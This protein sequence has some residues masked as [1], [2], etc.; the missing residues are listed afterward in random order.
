MAKKKP[1]AP[2]ALVGLNEDQLLEIIKAASELRE[3]LF[4]ENKSQRV[5]NFKNS[6]F[7]K[8]LKT[9]AKALKNSLKKKSVE[10]VTF[11][12]TITAKSNMDIECG[13]VD[14]DIEYD[15]YGVVSGKLK[16][17]QKNLIQNA[18]DDFTSNICSS[19]VEE[20]FPTLS[21]A[22]EENIRVAVEL[23]DELNAHLQ[24]NWIE[25]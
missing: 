25:L 19:G 6:D 18:L 11:N 20:L 23:N 17:N 22:C 3:K 1:A 10:K 4:A 15:I 21:D 12:I 14:G 7:L 16:K 24:N 13:Y 8:N 2:A 9:S 5:A